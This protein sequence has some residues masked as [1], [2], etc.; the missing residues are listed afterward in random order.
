MRRLTPFAG[1][2]LTAAQLSASYAT[3]VSG[4]GGRGVTLFFTNSLNGDVIISLDGGTTQFLM[5]P[6]GVG[7]ALDLGANDA[8]FSGTVSAKDGT[9]AATTGYISCGVVRV[10]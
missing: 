6:A 4:V 7:L 10:L 3:L 5:L 8:E 9:T 1:A 2:S